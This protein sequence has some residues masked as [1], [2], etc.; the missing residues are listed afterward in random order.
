MMCRGRYHPW[1]RGIADL[2]VGAFIIGFAVASAMLV[3]HAA[4]KPP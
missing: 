4:R 3:S 1:I 2:L